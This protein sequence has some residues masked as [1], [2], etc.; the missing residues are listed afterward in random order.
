MEKPQKP[1]TPTKTTEATKA[2]KPGWKTTKNIKPK[3]TPFL[4]SKHALLLSKNDCI[5]IHFLQSNGYIFE[6][7]FLFEEILHLMER[8]LLQGLFV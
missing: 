4:Y 8:C 3:N 7:G 1:H 5:L 2:T 6:D